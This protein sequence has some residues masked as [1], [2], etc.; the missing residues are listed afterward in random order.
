MPVH[1]RAHLLGDVLG[2]LAANT[3]YENLELI[4]VDDG[5]TD[6][7][8]A[9]LRDFAAAGRLPA[10]RVIEGTAPGA[11]A[12]LNTAL[13]AATGELC[14]QLDDDVTVETPGWVESML[15][16]MSLDPSVGVITPKVVYDNGEIN[17]C[18]VNLID[19]WG[20]HDRTSRPKEPVGR[21]L[22]INRTERVMEG[23]GGAIEATAT[24]VDAA[25]GCCMMYRRADALDAGGYDPE[26][27]PVWFDDLDLCVKI[28]ALGRKAFY[29]PAVRLTHHLGWRFDPALRP[30]QRRS[31]RALRGDAIR[32]VG[33]RLPQA[34]IRAV[35]GRFAFDMTGDYSREQCARLRHHHAY[36]RTKWGWDALNPDLDEIRR[37]WGDTEICWRFDPDRRAAGERIVEAY[38]AR[39]GGVTRPG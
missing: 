34:A 3:T 28:R 24:E 17:A 21:R 19:P 37:R 12:S 6:E 7:S 39:L 25:V 23:D 38:E 4:A 9:M 32:G 2:H 16:L 1:N 18:G 10:M 5:S 36:W 8:V 14:V 33:R 22:W 27:S 29:T 31:L 30:K 20:W 11:I 13:H 15:A 26:W 35:E